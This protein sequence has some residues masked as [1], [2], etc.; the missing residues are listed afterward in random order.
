[1]WELR[2]SN[3]RV[4]LGL[5]CRLTDTTGLRV[6]NGDGNG[7]GDRDDVLG[8]GLR[9]QLSLTLKPMALLGHRL[10]LMVGCLDIYS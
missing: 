9:I 4:R 1:M 7:D 10:S 5:R 2:H 8:V 3:L 6:G